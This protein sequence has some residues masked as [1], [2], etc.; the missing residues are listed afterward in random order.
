[1]I[2]Y[3]E[4]AFKAYLEQNA[5]ITYCKSNGIRSYKFVKVDY[6]K[7]ISQYDIKDDENI[8]DITD[9]IDMYATDEE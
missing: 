1:L 4:G 9:E 8:P 3:N 6:E 5:G 2:L 7:Y